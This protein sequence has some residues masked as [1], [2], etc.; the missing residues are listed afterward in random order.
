MKNEQLFVEQVE[1]AVRR[2]ED[3]LWCAERLAC[4]QIPDLSESPVSVQVLAECVDEFK[5]DWDNEPSSNDGVT[6]TGVIAKIRQ[7]LGDVQ[8]GNVYRRVFNA[9]LVY[10]CLRGGAYTYKTVTQPMHSET[11]EEA[12]REKD[13]IRAASPKQYP[14]NEAYQLEDVRV[15]LKVVDQNDST[16]LEET[17]ALN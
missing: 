11:V 3:T 12:V 9:E 16:I 13:E 2:P 1:E 15:Y 17:F 5:F 8:S 14:G 7:I 6:A 10:S 4:V